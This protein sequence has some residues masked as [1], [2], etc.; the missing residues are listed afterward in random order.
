MP[1]GE[2]P[3][4]CS[5]RNVDLVRRSLNPTLEISTLICV[6]YDARTKLAD[7]VVTEGAFALKS[8]LFR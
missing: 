1:S 4:V 8:E 2:W 5:T 7:Q 6:M 3:G